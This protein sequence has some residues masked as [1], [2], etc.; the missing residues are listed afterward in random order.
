MVPDAIAYLDHAWLSHLEPSNVANKTR[1]QC[2][3]EGS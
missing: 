2:D 1:H 3:Y